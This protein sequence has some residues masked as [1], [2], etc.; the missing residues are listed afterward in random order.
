MSMIENLTK[1]KQTIIDRKNELVENTLK[2][3]G[4]VDDIKDQLKNYG[5]QLADL[6]KQIAMDCMPSRP[7]HVWN[8]M[9]RKRRTGLTL[10]RR[11]NS[12]EVERLSSLANVRTV[13]G[14]LRR[15]PP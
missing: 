9:T 11:R 7:R 13:S 3:G 14:M 1:Q 4:K 5:K 10:I 2:N 15:Y 8:R 12:A 6:D